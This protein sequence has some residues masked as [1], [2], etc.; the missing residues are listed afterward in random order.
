MGDPF[1]DVDAAG[2]AFLDLTVS[3]LET[4]GADPSMTPIID[5]YLDALTWPSGALSVEIGCGTGAVARRIAAR[6]A[7]GRV[8]GYDP[9]A[10]LIAAAR[11]RA[12]DIDNLAFELGSGEALPVEDGAATHAFLHTVLSHVPQP[13]VLVTEATR[14]LQPD[15][16]L[17]IC[18]CD[19][20]KISLAIDGADPLES[21]AIA[22][23]RNFVTNVWLT[24]SLRGLAEGAGLVVERFELANRIVTQ[25]DGNLA[26]VKF[27]GSWLVAQNVIGLPLAE[28]L[29]A[30]YDRRQRLGLLY[31]FTPFVTLIAR[32][33]GDRRD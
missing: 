21:C 9:S 25:G 20:S 3:A 22:F 33:P 12:A 4:R 14:I 11:E 32:K 18:D 1:Q 24:A 31:G 28:A 30:E 2:D 19:F 6:A 16:H 27:A 23:R 29:V 10:G 13:A 26:M 7:Q 15:G 8:V 5:S 17:V